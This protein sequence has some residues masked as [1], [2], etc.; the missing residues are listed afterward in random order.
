MQEELEK[1]LAFL[2]EDEDKECMGIYN[3][4]PS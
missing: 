4:G 1:D 2:V 3:K